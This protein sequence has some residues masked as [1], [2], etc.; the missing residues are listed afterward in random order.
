MSPREEN[1]GVGSQESGNFMQGLMRGLTIGFAV[2]R[3]GIAFRAQGADE[4]GLGLG[5]GL[6]S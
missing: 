2:N 1:P 5:L 4:L 6:G 3:Q